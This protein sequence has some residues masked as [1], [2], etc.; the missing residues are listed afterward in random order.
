MLALDRA[1]RAERASREPVKIVLV[2]LVS[3]QIQLDHRAV[4]GERLSLDGEPRDLLE[5]RVAHDGACPVRPDDEI[6]LL[7][8]RGARLRLESQGAGMDVDRVHAGFKLEPHHFSILFLGDRREGSQDVALEP[9]QPC[10]VNASV[11][12]PVSLGPLKRINL[13][14][15]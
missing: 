14:S 7:R 2:Q 15:K 12:P 1:R 13:S 8:G 4:V 10:R 11:A 5:H 6:E 3:D 9:V